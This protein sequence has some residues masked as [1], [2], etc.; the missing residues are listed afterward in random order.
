MFGAAYGRKQLDKRV[1]DERRDGLATQYCA[2]PDAGPEEPSFQDVLRRPQSY[3]QEHQYNSRYAC[4]VNPHAWPPAVRQ[5]VPSIQKIVIA[6]VPPEIKVT[7][8]L[9][10]LIVQN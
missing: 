9:G 4:F 10:L 5:M 6:E 2:Q 1:V 7:D 8:A 3:R